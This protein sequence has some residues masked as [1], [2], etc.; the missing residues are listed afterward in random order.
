MKTDYSHLPADK[1]YD[2]FRNTEFSK[3]IEDKLSAFVI[4]GTTKCRIIFRAIDDNPDVVSFSC[5]DLD[6][7]T[8][9]KGTPEAGKFLL[10]RRAYEDFRGGHSNSDN[11]KKDL[12]RIDEFLFEVKRGAK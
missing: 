5:F 8:T 2:I 12:K 3:V 9:C 10:T 6:T 1:Q 4:M 11:V 7:K